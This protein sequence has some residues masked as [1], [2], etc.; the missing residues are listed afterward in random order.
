MRGQRLAATT[1]PDLVAEP[2]PHAR[3]WRVIAAAPELVASA[4]AGLSLP[5]MIALVTGHLYWPVVGSIGLVAAIGA[6]IA[7][8]TSAEV[9][10]RSTVR[11]TV[12]AA[13]I[14][15][16]WCIVNCFFSAEDLFAHRDPATYNIAGRWLMDHGRMPIPTHPEFFGSPSGYVDQSAGFRNSSL[17]YVY[18]QGN[19]LLPVLLAAGGKV[20]GTGA[21][22]RGNVVLAALGLFVFFGLARR[23]VGPIWALV[24]MSAL[25][26]S[27]P[28]IF[29]ARDTYSE[30]LALLFLMGGLLLLHRAT[31][32]DRTRD[33]ALAGFVAGC[34]A[35]VRIDAYVALLAFIVVATVL[36]AKAQPGGRT[37][38]GQQVVVM[39][40]SAVVPAAVGWAD[41]ASLSSGYYHDE[42]HRILLQIGAGGLFV[43]LGAATAILAWR[44]AVRRWLTDGRVRAQAAAIASAVIVATFV[45]LISRPWWYVGHAGAA[46]FL[47]S[48][49]RA[50]GRP[51]DATRSYAEQSVNWQ[52]LYLGWPTVLL[53]VAGYVL[54]IRA[55]LRRRDYA[56]LGLLVMGLVMSALYLWNPQITP[57]QVYAS[58]RFVPVIFPGLLIAATYALR[59]I[60]PLFDRLGRVIGIGGA[61]CVLAIP[62]AATV[63]AFLI[64][65]EVPQLAQVEAICKQV[66][67]DGA[68]ILIN[69]DSAYSYQQ[70]LRSYCEVPVIGLPGAKPAQLATVRATVLASGRTLYA[71]STS[72]E[73]VAF[74]DGNAARFSSAKTQRWPSQLD[75]TPTKATI[76]RVTVYLGP[77][78]ADG[79]V[80]ALVRRGS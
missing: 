22:L 80:R 60:Y 40:A 72:A 62:L 39:I 71:L 20:F 19:H 10:D 18:A 2:S 75:R 56:L 50:A 77:V 29:V 46:L 13:A 48:V 78:Q 70:T 26:L 53:A 44:P 35:L 33:Y 12:V 3:R 63:P 37:R 36:L 73:G 30:P 59:R 58:R 4:M 67:P 28:V 27:I 32:F 5:L 21:V 66:G 74:A 52:A 43:V 1:A 34:A 41:V 15:T 23:I 9:I 54:L 6:A 69:T 47:I 17:G 64:R 16:L 7:C 42:R 61:V 14:L 68:L 25:A 24:A 11:A 55:L 57:D 31:T 65:E 8:R 79:T 76:E 38:V 51:P 45:L 49:Q